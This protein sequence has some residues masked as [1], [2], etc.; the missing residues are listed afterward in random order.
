MAHEE[1]ELVVLEKE[2]FTAFVK[3]KKSLHLQKVQSF[4]EN[5]RLSSLFSQVNI[6]EFATKCQIKKYP[7]NTIIIVR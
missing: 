3:E 2:I 6:M 5:M 4:L 7:S 1:T